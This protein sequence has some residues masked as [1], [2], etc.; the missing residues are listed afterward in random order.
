MLEKIITL[1]NVG[2]F[3]SGAP[4]AV[5]FGKATLVYADNAR[6]KSTLSAILRAC[7]TGDS[8]ALSARITID[9]STQQRVSLRFAFPSGAKTVSFENGKWDATVPHL[10]V[11]D[12]SFIE[13]NVYAGSEVDTDHHQALLD[14]AIGRAAVT[15]KKHV[16]DCAAKQVAETRARTTA[17]DKLRGYRGLT[18]LDSF[19]AL[20]KDDDP[21]ATI[22]DLE[23][24]I[25]NARESEAILARP[26]LKPLALPVVNFDTFER[27]LQCSFEKLHE[28]ART[29]VESHLKSHG[30]RGAARWL[31]QGQAFHHNDSCPFCGQGTAGLELIAAYKNYFNAEYSAHMARSLGLSAAAGG[32]DP[33]KAVASWQSEHQANVE[34]IT[35]WTSQLKL[36]CPPPDFVQLLSLVAKIRDA[37]QRAAATKAERP[38]E[39]V[40]TEDIA[41]ARAA[42]SALNCAL[43]QYNDAIVTADEAIGAFKNGLAA[44]NISS[45][46]LELASAKLRKTRHL[47]EVVEIINQRNSADEE[48]TRYETEKNKARQELD[49]L[50]SEVLSRYQQTINY[51]LK[52]FGAPFSLDRL[53]YTYQG[54]TT[55]RTEY[56]IRLRGKVVAAGRRSSSTISFQ[57]ALSDGDKRTLALA[58]FL[59]RVLDDPDVAA[60]I[61]VL[62]DVFASLDRHRRSQTIAAVGKLIQQCAQV[63]IL[64]HDAYFLR[65]LRRRLSAK[66]NADTV[67]LEIRCASLGY[68]EV[69][70]CNLTELC[71][72]D[73]YKRYRDLSNYI[74]GLT[75]PNRLSVA[76]ALRPLV[77]GNLHRRFPGW[78]SEGLTFGKILEQVKQAGEGNPL[79]VL[80][81]QLQ[82]LH[83]FNDFASAFHHDPAEVV[84]QEDVSDAELRVYGQ[85]AL[86]FLHYGR[87]DG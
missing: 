66:R 2:L 37:L 32:I 10:H 65:D 79:R 41:E 25:A 16:D 64:G 68:S 53:G 59:A 60:S 47:P 61:V 1:Q 56:A 76:Q 87:I 15:K 44:E 85:Q 43:T 45:L 24:R 58:F 52:H 77:E 51:W 40:G 36:E 71:A 46:Q 4:K 67:T 28:T 72:S 9:A 11:F 17:E 86:D 12:Q 8:A 63:I 39:A 3:K 14:F 81:P 38:L 49:A 29:L 48:R 22:A 50:M 82:G 19:I 5:T 33:D 78:L 26:R 20:T 84:P 62:D 34:R 70:E 7:S 73:Y 30:G 75:T 27:N 55:P 23:R 13:H 74:A 21:D 42:M 6:G 69:G 80:Q 54:G 83:N 18:S 31:E 57:T 35:S